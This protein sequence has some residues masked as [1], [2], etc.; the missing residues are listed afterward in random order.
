MSKERIEKLGKG[1]C[2]DYKYLNVGRY[3][4]ITPGINPLVDCA[5]RCEADFGPQA[6]FYVN[7]KEQCGCS[8][9]S[10]GTRHNDNDYTSYRILPTIREILLRR[11]WRTKE[12]L[13][14]MSHSDRRNTL[15]VE[16]KKYGFSISELQKLTD[17]ELVKKSLV[18]EK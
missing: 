3:P 17:A 16:L 1:Y 12:E 15:I 11:K 6:A 18:T 2:K 9:G 13:G 14:T 7:A 5:S 8:K 4:E 10:C